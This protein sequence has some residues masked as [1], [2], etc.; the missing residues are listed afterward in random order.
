VT[1]FVTSGGG[2]LVA[3]L[4]FD[5]MFD[6]QVLWRYDEAGHLP[7]EVLASISGYYRRV[8]TAARPMNR[9]VGAVMLATVVAIVLQIVGDDAP[10]WVGWA[11]L[12]LAGSAIAVAAGHTFPSAV[13]L[14]RRRDSLEMQARLARS[15]CRDHL[16]C[17]GAI[18]ALL[19]IQLAFA[20]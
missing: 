16:L 7:E 4:W 1:A 5:L 15:I 17:L 12:G 9:L 8:T 10:R 6:V 20:A 19:A 14:G 11:S 2:F 3:V 13:R 18:T